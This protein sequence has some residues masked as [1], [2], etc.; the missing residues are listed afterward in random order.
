MNSEGWQ[1]PKCLQDL[2]DYSNYGTLS[3]T[4]P[5][6]C[7]VLRQPLWALAWWFDHELNVI[8]TK[9]SE[10]YTWPVCDLRHIVPHVQAFY[11]W[12][13]YSCLTS[14]LVSLKN[15][16]SFYYSREIQVGVGE[17]SIFLASILL[18]SPTSRKQWATWNPLPSSTWT[19]FPRFGDGGRP[20]T[21]GAFKKA[22]GG[23]AV[24]RHL[25][26][27][28]DMGK[29]EILKD[30]G[31]VGFFKVLPASS[32]RFFQLA[33]PPP[34]LWPKWSLFTLITQLRWWGNKLM[35]NFGA[36]RCH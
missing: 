21:M 11:M 5:C 13:N 26:H 8:V 31:H 25:R 16:T 23:W 10:L 19:N 22:W 1:P 33:S 3:E 20:T 15:S 18:T 12:V 14:L 35:A 2:G 24:K 32:Q 9:Y 34:S 6:P 36:S 30:M 29:H 4:V 27:L 17:I 7:K 28:G